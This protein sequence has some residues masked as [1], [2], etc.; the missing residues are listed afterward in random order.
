MSAV[1]EAR[2][3]PVRQA[4]AEMHYR[5]R[6]ECDTPLRNAGA[7]FIGVAIGCLPL[8]GLHL[9]L[10]LLLGRLAGV[11]RI[12]T[13]LASYINNPFTAPLVLYL[14][15]GLGYW[16]FNG[17]W[18]ILG[19]DELRAVG[20][21][22][23]G[24][25]LAVGSV[26]LGGLLGITLAAAA[27][28]VSQ[29]RR[30]DPLEWDLIEATAKPY[31]ST[32]IIN[33]EYVRGKLRYD[34]LHLGLLKTGLLP[35]QGRLLDL[36]CGQGIL[37]TLLQTAAAFHIDAKWRPDWPIP[38]HSLTLLGVDLRAKVL[39]A[40]R[41]ALG[42]DGALLHHADLRTWRLPA[43]ETAL[44]FDVLFY[45][46]PDEQQDVIAR[47]AAVLTPGGLLLLREPDA[48][49]GWRFT[50]TR[51][52]ERLCALARGRWRQRC[53]YRGAGDWIALLESH[54]FSVKTHSMAAGTPFANVLFEAHKC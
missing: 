24:R 16:L 23:F 8:Y 25:D 52:A 29:R 51:G 18:P 7:V 32:G 2:R 43:C 5:L 4:L 1:A 53:H 22:N 20:I 26:V 11:N 10:C 21:W 41:T 54:G 15:F 14:E 31:L 28:Q 46:R 47:V 6:T 9:P 27:F 42:D 39:A 45:L 19:L 13:Y 50:L 36:G 17:H 34:P 35:P 40:A 33:W 48:D 44:L 12:T 37:L 30:R 38:P 3:R 49:A